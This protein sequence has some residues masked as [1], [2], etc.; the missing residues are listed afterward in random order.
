MRKCEKQIAAS[1]TKITAGNGDMGNK[2]KNPQVRCPRPA[3]NWR[4]HQWKM[5]S[6]GGKQPGTVTEQLEQKAQG[7]RRY[8]SQH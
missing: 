1:G 7:N 4:N 8:L 5:W 6:T 3:I 2:K